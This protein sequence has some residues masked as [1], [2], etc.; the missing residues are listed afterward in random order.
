MQELYVGMPL[1][2]VIE[3]L[4]KVNIEKDFKNNILNFCRQE[5]QNGDSRIS[6]EIELSML[7]A[8][9]NNSDKINMP[10]LLS[11]KYKLI[12]VYT[13]TN[14][15]E[16]KTFEEFI[17]NDNTYYLRCITKNSENIVTKVSLTHKNT[18]FMDMIKNGGTEDFIIDSNNDGYVN[19]RTVIKKRDNNIN[20]MNDINL[21]GKKD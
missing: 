16:T 9:I 6:N 2:D 4:E 20:I 17:A 15:S 12:D 1:L 5:L 21:D 14:N 8:W 11:D 3:L 10:E 13:D 18:S 7:K 19:S